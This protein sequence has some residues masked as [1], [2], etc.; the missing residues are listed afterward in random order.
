MITAI[1]LVLKK[2][3]F[4]LFSLFVLFTLSDYFIDSEPPYKDYDTEFI[5]A[6]DLFYKGIETDCLSVNK[7]SIEY[8]LADAKTKN[9][10]NLICK[11][12]E[13][14]PFMS[15]YNN[16]LNNLFSFVLCFCF[17]GFIFG[18]KLKLICNKALLND[19]LV[20]YILKV[21]LTICV[22]VLIWSFT[23]RYFVRP[24][25]DE[26]LVIICLYLCGAIIGFLRA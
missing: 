26:L 1:L 15:I 11:D 24:E 25:L 14:T 13:T 3:F 4:P 8:R 23:Q 6:S 22:V 7:K 16:L 19:A 10:L 9:K 17:M 2:I 18:L 12:S 5:K 21:L 20:T